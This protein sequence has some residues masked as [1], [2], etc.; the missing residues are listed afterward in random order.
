[1]SI[2]AIYVVFLGFT[3]ILK[4]SNLQRKAQLW[5]LDQSN[6][7]KGT[8]VTITYKLGVSRKSSGKRSYCFNINSED[9]LE[10]GNDYNFM[11]FK[12][13]FD[14]IFFTVNQFICI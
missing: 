10:Y 6:V 2:V 1:M 13:G 4:M 5:S 11:T 12:Y 9:L 7:K 8:D 14:N 3:N